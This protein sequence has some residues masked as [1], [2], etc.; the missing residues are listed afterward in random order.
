M[1]WWRTSS[2]ATRPGQPVL[3]G[4]V[5][6]EKSE[7][8]AAL[9]KKRGI[10]HE[11][12]NAKYH[13]RE[14][15]IIAQAGREGAVTIAT[16]MAGRGTDILLGGNPDFLS[17]EILRKKGVDPA[18]ARARRAG[19]RAGGGPAGHRARARPGG[20]ARRAAHRGHRA[21][22]VAPDRQPAARPLRPSGRSRLL[23]VLSVARRRS[24][25]HL[26]LPADPEDH[27][28]PRHGGGRADRAPARHAGHRHRAEAGGDPQLRDPQAP[29]RVRRRD[30]QAAR[31]HLRHA[32]PDPG[33][34]R[35]RPR[36]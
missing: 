25:A 7:R 12:L 6:I 27:G 30:E 21:S 20:G 3:V 34:A 36:P 17:K 23:A 15:E 24:A 8:L 19:H 18:T 4:T 9:L 16:N 31:D 35:A 28:P 14:A 32:A 33:R 13:E 11:V 10:R 5:S 22:R 26:R 2:S 1:R 29:A